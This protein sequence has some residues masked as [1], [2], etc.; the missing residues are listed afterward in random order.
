MHLHSKALTDRHYA[1]LTVSSTARIDGHVDTARL[2]VDIH[3]SAEESL[4]ILCRDDPLDAAG[5][6]TERLSQLG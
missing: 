1:H 2:V 6:H 5:R 4:D 3:A